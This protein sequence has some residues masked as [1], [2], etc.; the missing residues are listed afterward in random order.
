MLTLNNR[1][2][3]G[4]SCTLADVWIDINVGIRWCGGNPE[5]TELKC[6]D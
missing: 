1:R 6:E 5:S 2:Q 4:L 3:P